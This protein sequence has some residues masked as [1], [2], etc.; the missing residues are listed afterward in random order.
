MICYNLHTDFK[1]PVVSS[2]EMPDRNDAFLL[3]V[4]CG[5]E[6]YTYYSDEIEFDVSGIYNIP[7]Y[8]DDF[9]EAGEIHVEWEDAEGVMHPAHLVCGR[10][11]VGEPRARKIDDNTGVTPD[12][13]EELALLCAQQHAELKS[14]I[15]DLRATVSEQ[16]RTIADQAALIEEMRT[17]RYRIESALLYRQA[18]DRGEKVKEY[19]EAQLAAGTLP[20]GWDGNH[21][22][23]KAGVNDF[24]ILP[25][26][27]FD[28]TDCRAVFANDDKLLYAEGIEFADTLA[29]GSVNANMMFYKCSG[30]LRV[31]HILNSGKIGIWTGTFY[32]CPALTDWPDYN[33]SNGTHFDMFFAGCTIRQVR[34]IHLPKAKDI[35]YICPASLERLGAIHAPLATNVTAI[36]VQTVTRADRID[37]DSAQPD[38]YGFVVGNMPSRLT[39]LTYL[40]L[41]NLGKSSCTSYRLEFPY[42]GY[43]SDENRGSLVDSLLTNSHDRAAAGMP[44]VT[45]QLSSRSFGLL[46]DE[47]KAAITAKGFTLTIR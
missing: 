23:A 6:S 17:D 8:A 12:R 39:A 25:H 27:V 24:Y 21:P 29:D 4:S 20:T 22:S 2:P 28:R 45:V 31:P 37:M 32:G 14:T 3:K 16:V 30:M 33:Y 41:H 36:Q 18:R 9:S 44:A 10:A 38:G 26:I 1:L 13:I 43:G 11:F 5:T 7:C 34:E 42:W 19:L 47:E 40:L 35:H 15:D 46:T